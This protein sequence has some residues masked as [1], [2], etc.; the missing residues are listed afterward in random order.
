MARSLG[1]AMDDPEDA[2]ESVKTALTVQANLA[3]ARMPGG[4]AGSGG[5]GVFP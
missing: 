3:N 2:A 1:M 5:S 4:V